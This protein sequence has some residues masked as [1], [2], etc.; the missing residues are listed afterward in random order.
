MKK[1]LVVV[2]IVV[3]YSFKQHNMK[4]IPPLKEYI[5]QNSDLYDNE[6]PMQ[7]INLI[8]EDAYY[9]VQ[10]FSK[11]CFSLILFRN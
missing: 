4:T 2:N 1:F 7:M 11:V 10:A 6:Q 5:A 9:Y 3:N 8:Y